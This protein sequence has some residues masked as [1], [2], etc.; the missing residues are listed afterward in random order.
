M[1]EDNYRAYLATTF[2]VTS[3]TQLTEKQFRTAF[4]DYRLRWPFK[5]ATKATAAARPRADAPWWGKYTGRGEPGAAAFLT[6]PQADEIARLEHILGWASEP[7]RLLGFIRRQLGL[8]AN[9]HPAVERL[10]VHQATSVI[11]G[12][13]KQ[14][15]D[16]PTPSAA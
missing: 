10:M 14:T 5:R 3:T 7:A 6:Q 13:K 2:G 8:P 9:V 4:R 16:V 11:T 12:L 1:S 15:P